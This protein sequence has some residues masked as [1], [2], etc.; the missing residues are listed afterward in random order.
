MCIGWL[1]SRIAK[2]TCSVCS[3]ICWIVKTGRIFRVTKKVKRIKIVEKARRAAVLFS[4][5]AL[6]SICVYSWI[7]CANCSL[8]LSFPMPEG[9]V[10]GKRLWIDY[11]GSEMGIDE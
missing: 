7:C 8:T 11:L 4:M 5:S 2:D 9:L 6:E 3:I 1:L 10:I